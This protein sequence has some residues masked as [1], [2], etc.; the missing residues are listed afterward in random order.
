MKQKVKVNIYD[1]IC[2]LH[3]VQ[4]LFVVGSQLVRSVAGEVV[5]PVACSSQSDVDHAV[6]KARS[7]FR[8]WSRM[9]GFE[10]GAVLKKA[11]NIIR[12]CIYSDDKLKWTRLFLT[13][14]SGLTSFPDYCI[15][16]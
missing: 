7:A 11:A 13:F 10:R 12:V 16:H 6:C 14:T 15:A 8:D 2:I 9:S 5:R 1:N 3:S 4:C